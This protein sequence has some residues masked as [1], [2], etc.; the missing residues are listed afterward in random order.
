[1]KRNNSILYQQKPHNVAA[2]NLHANL[3]A[4]RLFCTFPSFFPYRC[5][6][7]A[8]LFSWLA[9]WSS[10]SLGALFQALVSWKGR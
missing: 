2:Q 3:V 1:M 7:L 8:G 4:H 10:V 9:S 6:V 5:M